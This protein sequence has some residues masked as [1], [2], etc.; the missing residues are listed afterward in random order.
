MSL[1]T[2]LSPDHFEYAVWKKKELLCGIDEVGRGCL[3]GPVVVC[4]AILPPHFSHPIKDSKLLSVRQRE[5]MYALLT[6]E[7][8]YTIVIADHSYIDRHNIYR[9]TQQSMYKACGQL[10]ARYPLLYKKVSTV[11]SDAM[12]LLS[13]LLPCATPAFT[14]YK[15]EQFSRT[16]AAAS[17]IAKVTRD[18]L[19]EKIGTLFPR[20]SFHTHKGY[21]TLHHRNVLA[22]SPHSFIHRLSFLKTRKNFYASKPNT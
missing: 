20:F 21:P 13:T 3:A 9:S 5:K 17:I 8:F 2:S 6:K 10:A 22:C 11:V 12:P 18:Q 14:F 16:I 4:A 1:I 15:G 7:I 19:M